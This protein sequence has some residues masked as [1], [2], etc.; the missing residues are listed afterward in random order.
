MQYDPLNIHD[1]RDCFEKENFWHIVCVATQ[2][3]DYK[4]L[5]EY[6]KA[7]PKN[8]SITL[9]EHPLNDLES[10]DWQLLRD[11][12]ET[13]D[14]KIDAVGELGFDFKGNVKLQQNA[15][16]QQAQ[17]ALD[18]NLP[19]IL[20][21]REVESETM[22]MIR[23]FPGLRGVF[24]CFTGSRR[25]AEFAIDQGW[26]VSFS[27]I[28]TFRNASMLRRILKIVPLDLLLVETDAPFLTPEPHRRESNHPKYIKHTIEMISKTRDVAYFNLLNALRENLGRLL[29]KEIVA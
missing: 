15:F 20:H 21:T 23:N 19:I 26:F 5:L 25:L 22:A 12:I 17:I 11:I 27:G 2:T 8:V 7:F 18:N 28:I 9:G 14:V 16:E 4:K 13:S 3:S 24:H 29:N 10:V 6:K 1:L